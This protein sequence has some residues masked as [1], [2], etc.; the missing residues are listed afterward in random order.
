VLFVSSSFS[1]HP[2]AVAAEDATKKKKSNENEL[3]NKIEG[4]LDNAFGFIFDKA[5]GGKSQQQQREHRSSILH[6][7][8]EIRYAP[9]FETPPQSP[10][11]KKKVMKDATKSKLLKSKLLMTP[12][13]PSSPTSTATKW[14]PEVWK[15]KKQ[16]S[17][18]IDDSDEVRKVAD[19]AEKPTVASVV[20]ADQ[21]ELVRQAIEKKQ[22]RLS[23]QI[24]PVTDQQDSTKR[25]SMVEEPTKTQRD[26]NKSSSS[27][28]IGSKSLSSTTRGSNNNSLQLRWMYQNTLNLHSRRSS[29]LLLDE[30]S[31][32]DDADS[33][34][35]EQQQNESSS[36]IHDYMA[37][38]LTSSDYYKDDDDDDVRDDLEELELLELRIT[39]HAIAA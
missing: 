22:K 16:L 26:N 3:A 12:S 34:C 27:F 24:E 33:C 30:L 19:A 20:V 18:I 15:A 31:L 25:S 2:V 14:G 21:E 28:S 35:R 38:V 13:P 36:N 7:P 11:Q 6:N 4:V 32:S 9:S 1:W 39:R 37:P 8:S 17:P 10:V 23:G 5:G 29:I